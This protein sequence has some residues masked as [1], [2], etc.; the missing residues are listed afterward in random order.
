VSQDFH[1]ILLVLAIA[2]NKFGNEVKTITHEFGI[3]EILVQILARLCIPVNI[4]G[5]LCVLVKR[6]FERL[7]DIRKAVPQEVPENIQSVVG[8]SQNRVLVQ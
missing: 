7:P 4:T 6:I 5:G 8:I 3:P 2:A 1:K